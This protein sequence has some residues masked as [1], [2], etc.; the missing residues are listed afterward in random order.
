[1]EAQ[2]KK[3]DAYNKAW[4]AAEKARAKEIEAAQAAENAR[5]KEGTEG[6]IKSQI[7]DLETQRSFV[8]KDDTAEVGRIN[9]EIAAL[10]AQLVEIKS[11]GL[12][13]PLEETVGTINKL[14]E[15]LAELKTRFDSVDIVDDAS[16]QEALRLK[17]VIEETQTLLNGLRSKGT[18]SIE[19]DGLGQLRTTSG[20]I[21]ELE[22]KLKT[23]ESDR[24]KLIDPNEIDRANDE[25]SQITSELTRLKGI[26]KAPLIDDEN[27]EETGGLLQSLRNQ[28]RMLGEE[29]ESV[30]LID[31][32]ADEKLRD[33][34]NRMGVVQKRMS[35]LT[36]T[37]ARSMTGVTNLGYSASQV[38]R[39]APAF[40]Y[41]LNTGI[42]ALSN[43]LPILV[44]DFK[45]AKALA[46]QSG[47]SGAS[48]WKEM[49]KQIFSVAGMMTLAVVAISVAIKYIEEMDR[50]LNELDDRIKAIK[51]ELREADFK[52]KIDI[53]SNHQIYKTLIAAAKSD[54]DG[55]NRAWEEL[56]K[57]SNG[58]LDNVNGINDLTQEMENTL[59]RQADLQIELNKYQSEMNRL[60]EEEARIRER[61]AA[62]TTFGQ[63]AAYLFYWL[64]GQGGNYEASINDAIK[65]SLNVN[66]SSMEAAKSELTR[67]LKELIGDPKDSRRNGGSNAPSLTDMIPELEKQLRELMRYK[68]LLTDLKTYADVET[69]VN[70]ELKE[71]IIELN[72]TRAQAL[73]LKSEGKLAHAD[74]TFQLLDEIEARTRL[75]AQIK[76]DIELQLQEQK[77]IADTYDSIKKRYDLILDIEEKRI[78]E[79]ESEGIDMIGERINHEMTLTDALLNEENKRYNSE[80]TSLE[81]RIKDFEKKE[82]LTESEIALKKKLVEELGVL[83]Y[84]HENAIAHIQDMEGSR[85]SDAITKN[86]KITLDAAKSANELEFSEAEAQ[87]SKLL[88]LSKSFNLERLNLL[89]Q[90][91]R[92]EDKLR[93]KNAEEELKAA[94]NQ[95]NELRKRKARG[96]QVPDVDI[97]NAGVRVNK[98]RGDFYNAQ[99]T[100]SDRAVG[101]SGAAKFFLGASAV[102]QT[103]EERR[104]SMINAT[105]DAYTELTNVAVESANTILE[106]Q[107][108]A[109]DRE[110][111]VRQSSM[112]YAVE[113]AKR[114][115]TEL[116]NS[117][118]Q[119][120]N[121]SLKERR[122]AANI[123]IAINSALAIS[124][125]LVAVAKAASAG[126]GYA[127]IATVLAT[128]GALASG[129]AA[130][131]SMTSDYSQGYFK[132]GYTGDG[133][134]RE[135]AGVVHKQE[136][137]FS[138]KD[139]ARLG[140]KDVVEG[141]RTGK[142]MPYVIGRDTTFS[143][144]RIERLEG[145]FDEL[146]VVV[147]DSKFKQDVFFDEQGVG[148][149]TQKAINKERRRFAR[150]WS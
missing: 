26:G 89:H 115:N 47:Q 34:A 49:G 15:Q 127:S 21:G 61:A 90:R 8:N 103:N 7:K 24:V 20:I 123:Q 112:N 62:G 104:I 68:G 150:T 102:G 33:I 1:M 137:V 51:K 84:N 65:K 110:I 3:E 69:E 134:P 75:N 106:A 22:K 132:G 44:D 139:V 31:P 53:E 4:A 98:A 120:L 46:E 141:I 17:G 18:V 73:K 94:D 125:A 19:I 144:N 88:G 29:A 95:L 25:I 82:E 111:S 96:E 60:V 143:D 149:M 135:E 6:Y 81:N 2:K 9:K 45:A 109:L 148:I 83:D 117:E 142:N 58:M 122:K 40:L 43:N 64:G 85:V 86:Y 56:K 87:I 140:G 133:D 92:E 147:A 146:M 91:Y 30:Q 27:L 105:I 23:L 121:E 108:A 59:I 41:G 77:T 131:K 74:Y 50:E 93:T 57:N 76:K 138:Q 116:L 52:L 128:V 78:K 118:R 48:A 80:K 114:G 71:S 107:T 12:D 38:L 124:E 126:G 130:V 14:K 55:Y 16:A 28:L 35:E 119:A 67:V 37:S 10:K 97:V 39:E 5:P 72:L 63:K 66:A 70:D 99:K 42:M 113:L 136:I 36:S 79:G 11:I 145:K 13:I 101:V 32:K 100:E 129:Y 54:T